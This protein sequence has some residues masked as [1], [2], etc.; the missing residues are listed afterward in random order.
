MLP[1]GC[2]QILRLIANLTYSSNCLKYL[3]QH[4]YDLVRLQ[5]KPTGLLLNSADVKGK[6]MCHSG[7][8]QQCTANLGAQNKSDESKARLVTEEAVLHLI[9]SVRVCHSHPVLQSKKL[10]HLTGRVVSHSLKDQLA[11]ADLDRELVLCV[12]SKEG[13]QPTRLYETGR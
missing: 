13:L 9:E 6:S 8:H 2:S 4:P 10:S 5:F 7:Q 12:L 1:C 3:Q 11:L